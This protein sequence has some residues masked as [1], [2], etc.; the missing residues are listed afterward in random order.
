M[1]SITELSKILGRKREAVSRDI[2][3]FEGLGLIAL[4]KHAKT[5]VPKRVVQEI[6]IKL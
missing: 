2:R 5:R 3:F 6:A 1:L 4:E